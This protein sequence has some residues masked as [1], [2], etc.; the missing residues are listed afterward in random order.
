MITSRSNLLRMRKFSH[1][2]IEKIKTD[3]LGVTT[4]F[5]DNRTVYEIMWENTVQLGRP[6]MKAKHTHTHTHTHNM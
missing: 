6:Q 1:K 4:F 3:V 2:F 5:F